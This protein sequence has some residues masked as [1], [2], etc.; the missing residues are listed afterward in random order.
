MTRMAR[1]LR[2]FHA[3]HIE[4]IKTTIPLHQ[5]LMENSAFQEG[6]I[7]IHYLERLLK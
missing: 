7:D 2:E 6:G 4:P 3:P 5:R 1:A